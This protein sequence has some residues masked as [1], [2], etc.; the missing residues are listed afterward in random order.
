[1]AAPK[2]ANIWAPVLAYRAKHLPR[3]GRVRSSTTSGSGHD[4]DQQG[5]RLIL[6]GAPSTSTIDLRWLRFVGLLR[7]DMAAGHSYRR[8]PWFRDGRI[9]DRPGTLPRYRYGAT[10]P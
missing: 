6:P 8:R 3:Q 2:V 9:P 1:M 7:W 10:V 4:G 5:P